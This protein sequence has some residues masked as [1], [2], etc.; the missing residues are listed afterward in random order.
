MRIKHSFQFAMMTLL[1]AG[2]YAQTAGAKIESAPAAS[3]ASIVGV[4]QAD[5]DGL[6]F[7]T[8]NITDEGGGLAGAVLFYLHRRDP[9]KPM[10]STVGA[11]E[12]LLNPIFDG[13][14]LTFRVSHRRAHPP[15]TSQDLPIKFRLEFTGNNTVELF[16]GD[17]QGS[18]LVLTRSGD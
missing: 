18:G 12:P 5:M 11:P 3:T 1:A 8:L 4:W 7:V 6:P 9:G 15:S 13:K 17:D 10:T 2:L 14:T 16:R